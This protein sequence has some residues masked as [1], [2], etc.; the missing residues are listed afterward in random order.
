V[1]RLFI[2]ESVAGSGFRTSG[3]RIKRPRKKRIEQAARPFRSFCFAE[4]KKMIFNMVKI[5]FLF[6]LSARFVSFVLKRT[7]RKS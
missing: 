5:G 6:V 7:G 4:M 3:K 1:E 2:A